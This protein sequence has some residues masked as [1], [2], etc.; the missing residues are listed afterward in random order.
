MSGPKPQT[1]KTS[2]TQKIAPI[3]LK[4]KRGFY[5][6]LMCFKRCRQND[7]MANS[8]HPVQAAPLEFTLFVQTCLSVYLGQIKIYVCFRYPDPT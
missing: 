5:H 2:D 8:A 4:F 6:I 1:S 7:R 3:I